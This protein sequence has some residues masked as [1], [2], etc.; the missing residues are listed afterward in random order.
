MEDHELLIITLERLGL[1]NREAAAI[2]GLTPMTVSNY[3]TG[4][5]KV[6]PAVWRSLLE[7]EARAIKRQAEIIARAVE[8]GAPAPAPVKRRGRPRKPL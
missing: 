2:L 7:Y 6:K 5:H 8:L 3:T 1:S 4:A